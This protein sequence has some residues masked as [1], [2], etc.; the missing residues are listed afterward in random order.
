MLREDLKHITTE[1]LHNTNQISVRAA[2]C[3]ISVG[4]DTLYKIV[5]C[6]EDNGS[7]IKN[8]IKNVGRRTCE[9]LDELCSDVISKIKFEKPRIKIKE[10]S[11][12]INELTEQEREILLSLANLIF[13]TEDVINKKECVFS[14]HCSSSF[15]F[16]IDFYVK[17]GYFP[18]FWIL[19]QCLIS[20]KSRE[21]DILTSTFNIIQDKETL[22]LEEIAEKHNLT[23]ERVRQIRNNTFRK[24]FEI[25]DEIIEYKKDDDLIKYAELLQ[26]KDDWTYI[27]QLSQDA[28]INQESF[29]V[30]EYLKKEQC[31]LSVEFVVQIIAYLFRNTFS[32]F[33]GFE[34]S[35]RNRIWENTFLI[36]KTL[37]GIF[38]FE[39][40]IDEFTNHITDN[41]IEYDLNLDEFLPNSTC[42]TSVIDL[43]KFD[44]IVSVVKD[45]LLYEFH[46]YSNSDGL[47]TIPATKERNPLDI[48]Y[49]ILKGNGNPMHLDEIFTEFKKISPEHKYVDSTQLRPYL[50]RHENISF[51]NRKS[52]YTLKEWGHIKSG[53]IR[54]SIVEFLL[55]N[56]LPQAADSITEYVLQ[57][58]PETNI[59]S[60]RTTMFN[61]TKKRFVF[62][63][64][65]LFGLSNKEYPLEYEDAK[66]QE[67]Q[68][69]A[70]EQ[71][72]YDLEK[73]LS[74]NDHFPFSVS[75]NESEAS[76][77]RWWRIANRN[78]AELTEQQKKEIERIKK[79]YADFDT[80]KTTYEWFCHFNDFKLFILEN[81]RLP[82]ASGSEKFLYGW[83]RRA[84][85][86]FMNDKLNE[87]Q[88]MKYA[89]LFKEIGY[90]ER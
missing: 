69:K 78:I 57:H 47:I 74:E 21:I 81:R 2:N 15:S 63:N 10:V 83:F 1:H 72:L 13:E 7:F 36:Q 27:L 53:T 52:V 89:E 35:N 49:E 50:Q 37:A 77:Y 22:S 4:L 82:S 48:V 41:E 30:Q 56:D 61:D 65:N 40:F 24:T 5:S 70:F 54:D 86:D 67:V 16:A 45:I 75:D 60:V 79:Q 68:R 32:L 87:R 64:N 34:I 88:R 19:E 42:W 3:C 46:L 29:E 28:S 55:K 59:A 39:K 20:D 38:D 12:I 66:P 84:K 14:N 90:V 44:N 9:E 51:R 26:N 11:A 31:N 80:D 17:N 76:L 6:F 23:R 85:D 18:M 43:N 62:F 73:F 25:T 33:G 8:K 71:R 58:F